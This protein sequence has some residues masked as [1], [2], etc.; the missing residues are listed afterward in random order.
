MLEFP[1]F[2]LGQLGTMLM[3]WRSLVGRIVCC[4]LH[5]P[6]KLIMNDIDEYTYIDTNPFSY[7]GDGFTHIEHV[8]GDRTWNLGIRTNSMKDH[9]ALK[10]G[11]RTQV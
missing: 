6:F 5:S 3:C 11:R 1:Q 7:L 2:G 9:P 4:S 8:G 10:H